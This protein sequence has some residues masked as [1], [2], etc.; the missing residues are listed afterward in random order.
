MNNCMYIIIL[1]TRF[2]LLFSELVSFGD[3]NFEVFENIFP[4]QNKKSPNF[5]ECG[6]LGDF[7]ISTTA[8][9]GICV[10][11]WRTFVYEMRPAFF[12]LSMNPLFDISTHGSQSLLV[13]PYPHANGV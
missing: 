8:R 11:G 12:N 7:K 4:F 2:Q 9:S 3:R 1:L 5:P 10:D 6:K 13:S